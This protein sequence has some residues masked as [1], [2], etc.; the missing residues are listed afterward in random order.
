[1]K[2]GRGAIERGRPRGRGARACAASRSSPT[3]TWRAS[4][5]V[6]RARASLRAAGVDVAEFAAVRIEPTDGSFREAAAFA[7]DA[8][9]RRLRLGRRRLGDRHR[10]GGE[11]LRDL[12]GAV[13]ALRQ[14]AAG[15]GGAG[16][17]PARAAHR[18]P[19][20]LGDRQRVHRDH[21]LRLRRAR[22]QDGDRLAPAAPDAGHRRPR[23]DPHAARRRSSPRAASTCWPTRSSRSPPG[24]T[25]SAR[26]P[27]TPAGAPAL[28]GREPVQRPGL[29]RGAAA[30]GRATSSARCTTRATTRRARR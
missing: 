22:R 13:R 12:P 3:P 27:A 5:F 8:R 29:R 26:G 9:R 16:A 15:R 20:D 10:Q 18:L 21:D 6:E 1:M 24:R 30:A 4:A 14:R 7:R 28:A 17:G 25:R 11:P 19:D 2:F 23:R